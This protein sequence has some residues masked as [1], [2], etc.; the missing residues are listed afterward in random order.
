MKRLLGGVCL[1][2][3]LVAGCGTK[4]DREGSIEE[5]MESGLTRPQAECIIDSSVEEF[6]EEKVISDDD[7]TPEE[8]AI[9]T[10]IAFECIG[11]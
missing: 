6:G 7:P 5:L 3:L 8:E 1:V 9:L 2:A 4:L 11:G 10:E